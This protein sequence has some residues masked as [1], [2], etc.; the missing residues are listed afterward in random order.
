[1]SVTAPL[2]I[3][4]LL[5]GY[6]SR[7]FSPLEVIEQVLSTIAA[8]PD[9]RAWITLLPAEELRRRA[10]ALASL[11]P[12]SLPLYGVPF[13]IK[14]NID[15]ADVPTTAGC[16]AYA[17][18][19]STTAPVV[20]RLIAAGAL[21]IGKTNLDQFATGLVGTRSPWG[22]CRNSFDPQF[23]SGGSSSGSSVAV[24]TGQVSFA[25][26]T[27][28]AGSGRV[29][30][31][32]NNLIGLKPTRGSISTRGVVPA[33]RSL[34]CVSLLAL[35][36]SDAAAVAAVAQAFDSQDPYS[37][38]AQPLRARRDPTRTGFRFG[39]PKH[40]QLQFCGDHDYERL[41]ETAILHLEELGGVP[42]E[43]DL[44]PFL[45]AARLLYE[46]PW[47]AERYCA[48]GSF[49]DENPQAVLAV[50]RA[51]ISAGR[52]VPATD[53]FAG[54]H[55]LREL[56][57]ASE[58][59]WDAID[60]LI[61]PTA[62]TIYRIAAVE[63]DP[64]T[65]NSNLGIYTNFV[66]LFDL[67]AVAAPAG[68]RSDGLPFGI[69]LIGRAWTDHELLRLAAGFH[70]LSSPTLGALAAATPPPTASS[71]ELPS[72]HRVSVAV[73]G[74]HMQGLPL[75]HQI[76]ARG[77]YL[78]RLAHTAPTYKLYALRGSSPPRPGLVRVDSDGGAIE[79]ELWSMPLA[80][81]GDFVAA[82]PAP[83]GIGKVELADGQRVCGF[84]CEAQGVLGAE[85]V[86]SLGSWR[87]YLSR[88][89]P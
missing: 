25:L 30:A 39:V 53:A 48:V 65:L 2:L 75:N 42:V 41:F 19:P 73:C 38:A 34:D 57:R 29:P 36:A 10:R 67:A 3:S 78:L 81:F 60:V 64:M 20:A 82:I 6:R 51:I 11:A 47:I 66:N 77:G 43:I 16:R 26:G 4:N 8:A 14:D 1:M 37:R 7:R 28:T 46:G 80:S 74:A 71:S 68:F 49:I 33:C 50:T 31:A 5:H 32:F 45:A 54:Q 24:A 61:T 86:T 40:S 84:I 59:A 22:A 44:E 9:R 21:P 15:L 52:E 56:Q 27:D 12:E 17:Y 58:S 83:L 55:R 70:Q 79:L 62:P 87:R 63:A 35:T 88:A 18:T 85:D 89:A 23:I 13:A 76:T 72:E 69:S